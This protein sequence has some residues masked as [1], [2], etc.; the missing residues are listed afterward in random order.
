MGGVVSAPWTDQQVLALLEYQE[1]DNYH[2]YTCG[3]GLLLEPTTQGW[4]CPA[5]GELA[6]RSWVHQGTLE[7]GDALLAKK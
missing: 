7:I 6:A 4:R 2:P 3:C 1:C 5:C